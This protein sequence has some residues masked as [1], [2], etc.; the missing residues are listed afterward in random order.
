MTDPH[1]SERDDEN[2]QEKLLALLIALPALAIAWP[3]PGNPVAGDF[4]GDLVFRLR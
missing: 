4:E 2:G 1:P 3:G